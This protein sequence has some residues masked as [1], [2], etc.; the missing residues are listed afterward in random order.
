MDNDYH[1]GIDLGGTHIRGGLVK[2]NVLQ[3]ILS[4]PVHA[5]GSVEEVLEE[6]FSLTDELIKS[7]TIAANGGGEGNDPVGSIGIGVPGL[8]NVEEGII[9]DLVNIPSWKELPLR[10]WMEDRYQIP[11]AIDNDANCFALGEFYFGKGK[12]C[13]AMIGITIKWAGAKNV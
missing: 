5:R 10:K 6:L 8:V 3:G 2:G 1:I 4:R 9:Y 7:T 13:E 12:G 11:V